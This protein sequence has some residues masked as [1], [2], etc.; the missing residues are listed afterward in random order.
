MHVDFGEHFRRRLGTLGRD[1]DLAAGEG[2]AL[3]ESF[4]ERLVMGTA[5][6]ATEMLEGAPELDTVYV[7]IGLGSSI[8]GMAAGRKALGRRTEIVGVV[9]AEAPS[10]ARSRS[11]L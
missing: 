5:T 7:P 11:R 4:H 1:L 9:A 3:V 2:L 10:Y 6:Y 8:C